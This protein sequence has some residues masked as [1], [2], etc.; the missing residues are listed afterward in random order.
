[1]NM[2]IVCWTPET[3]NTLRIC[4]NYCFSTAT[5]TART[6]LNITSNVRCLCCVL[7]A[8]F[9]FSD[10]LPHN[11]HVLYHRAVQYNGLCLTANGFLFWGSK[12]VP[13]LHYKQCSKEI[14]GKTTSNLNFDT[15]QRWV[16]RFTPLP[17]YPWREVAGKHWAGGWWELGLLWTLWRKQTLLPNHESKHDSSVV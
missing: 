8:P 17:L 1:M 2:H 12:V 7:L 9:Q 16:V 6:R 13:L 11:W 4:N 14:G 10:F 3:R 5:I 15:K